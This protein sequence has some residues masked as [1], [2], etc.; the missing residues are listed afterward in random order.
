METFP[1][2]K[3]SDC[4]DLLAGF[5]FKSQHFTDRPDDIPLVKGENVSQG[6]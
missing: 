4:V 2:A 5:A 3:L 1:T 6:W